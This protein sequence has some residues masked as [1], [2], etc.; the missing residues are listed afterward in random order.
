MSAPSSSTRPV[1]HP[2]TDSS[3]I[4][5][6]HRSRVLLPHPDGPMMAVTVW[7]GNRIDTSVSTVRG[8]NSAVSRAVSSRSRASAGGAMTLP[9]GAA[10]GEGEQQHERHQDQGGGPGEAV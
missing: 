5:L 8:P 1:T 6:R 3:C 9:H 4:R 2:P 7:A 10:G